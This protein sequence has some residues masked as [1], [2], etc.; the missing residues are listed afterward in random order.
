MSDNHEDPLGT[1]KPRM[2]KARALINFI[3]GTRIEMAVAAAV[4]K[5]EAQRYPATPAV[6]HTTGRIRAARRNRYAK[7]RNGARECERRRRQLA[8]GQ[9]AQHQSVPMHGV[10]EQLRRAA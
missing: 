2:T 3:F 9:L 5:I 7:V 4:A 8:N 6:A 10:S 1:H